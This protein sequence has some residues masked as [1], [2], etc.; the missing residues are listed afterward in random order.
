MFPSVLWLDVYF[1]ATFPT[2]AKLYKKVIDKCNQI[3]RKEDIAQ[4]QRISGITMQLPSNKTF[5]VQCL[6][7]SPGNK[8]IQSARLNGK[9][10]NKS[11]FSHEELMQ[12]GKLELVMGEYPNKQWASDL[13]DVPPSFKM[14]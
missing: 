2:D 13:S 7:Y 5:T 9:E 10:W 4:R 14:D 3:A 1:N 8:Y 12:G 6:N 11:W